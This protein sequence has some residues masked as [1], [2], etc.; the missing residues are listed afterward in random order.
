MSSVIIVLIFKT[1]MSD[2]LKDWDTFN[3]KTTSVIP[4]I[5]IFIFFIYKEL[6]VFTTNTLYRGKK[7]IQTE[8]KIPQLGNY[9]T[10]ISIC[11]KIQRFVK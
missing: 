1:V 5:C 9:I 2:T 6:E 8:I 10:T 4:L 3:A 11:K 7:E